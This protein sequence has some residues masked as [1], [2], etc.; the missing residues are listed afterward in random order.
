MAELSHR[1]EAWQDELT[2]ALEAL[3][4]SACSRQAPAHFREDRWDRPGGGGGRSRVLEGG[5]VFERAGVNFSHVHGKLPEALAATMP[6]DGTDFEAVG[7]SLV[8]HPLSPMVPTTHANFRRLRRGSASWIGGG[9][10]LTPY[11]LFEEDARH[12]HRTFKAACEPG[13]YERHKEEC[14]R[15]FFLP[16]RGEARGIGGLFFDYL[17]GE[18]ERLEAQLSR[19]WAAF[20]PAYRPIVERRRGLAYG[21]RERAFQLWRRGRY[22]EFN[23]LYDRGTSFGLSTGGRAE[24]ILMSLPPLVRWEYDYQAET[25]SPE[26]RLLE[27]LRKPRNWAEDE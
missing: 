13:F 25:G 9:A 7:V 8:L 17:Q 15:Y 20:L 27:V 4:R 11:V 18:P 19:L 24:S 12:F 26:A 21:E 3:E 10:D 23:L 2:A 14:D 5:A 6:G 16:H 1:L 22:V